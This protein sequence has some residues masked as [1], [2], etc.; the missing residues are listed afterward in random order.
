MRTFGW[1]SL[2]NGLA[3]YDEVPS[4][5]RLRCRFKENAYQSSVGSST[6]STCGFLMDQ[7]SR[8][9]TDDPGVSNRRSNI[10]NEARRGYV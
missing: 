1:I 8:G 5:V 2:N 9:V 10:S 3:N 7:F 4:F 6:S